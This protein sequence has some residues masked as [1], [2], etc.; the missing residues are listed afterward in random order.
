M[1]ISCSSSAIQ[2]FHSTVS[3][4]DFPYDAMPTRKDCPNPLEELIVGASLYGEY[5][6][7]L[8]PTHLSSFEVDVYV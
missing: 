4:K 2:K 8:G 7:S 6:L 3:T 5:S 1:V